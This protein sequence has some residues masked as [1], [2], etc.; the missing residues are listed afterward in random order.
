VVTLISI[1]IPTFNEEKF[2]PNL[3]ESIRR[4]TFRK[5]EIIIADN[6]SKDKTREIAKRFGCKIVDGGLPA[7]GRNNGARA[8]KYNLLLFLDADVELRDKDFLKK[9]VRKYQK[10]H[11]DLASGFALSTSENFVAL[12]SNLFLGIFYFMFQFV[13]F[14]AFGAF[15]FTTRENHDKIG[16]FDEKLECCEDF[17]YVFDSVRK[18]SRFAFLTSPIV[19]VYDR[20]LNTETKLKLLQRFIVSLMFSLRFKEK[21]SFKYFG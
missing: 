20:R 10:K 14:G 17:K 13:P 6:F 8:A 3:L 21:I 15:L 19:S 1:I 5:Y 16:G 2:L 12:F 4:Q 9:L 11:F 7:V 18:G